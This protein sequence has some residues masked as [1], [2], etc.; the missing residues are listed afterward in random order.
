ME[1]VKYIKSF[2]TL[3][4]QLSRMKIYEKTKIIKNKDSAHSLCYYK[5]RKKKKTLKI[6]F[7]LSTNIKTVWVIKA[8][9][10]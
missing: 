5:K 1:N 2:I 10:I 8:F 3:S 9:Y 4:L 7:S 6:F